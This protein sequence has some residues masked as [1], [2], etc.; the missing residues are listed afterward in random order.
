MKVDELP[1]AETR[2]SDPAARAATRA[3][4]VFVGLRV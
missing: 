4:T 2:R 3:A 1:E